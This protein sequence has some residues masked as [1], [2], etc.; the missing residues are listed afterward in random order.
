MSTQAPVAGPLPTPLTDDDHLPILT[1][2]EISDGSFEASI[3][4]SVKQDT[5]HNAIFHYLADHKTTPGISIKRLRAL[6]NQ[7]K[8]TNGRLFRCTLQRPGGSVLEQRVVGGG[9]RQLQQ[10]L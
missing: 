10:K 5:L 7:Y 9:A 4:D 3:Q 6:S 8:V 2:D 1:A